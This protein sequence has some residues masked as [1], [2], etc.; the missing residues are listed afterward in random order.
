MKD[1][2]ISTQNLFNIDYSSIQTYFISLALTAIFT[3]VIIVSF[4]KILQQI[5]KRISI[6]EEKKK[7]Q[8]KVW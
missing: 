7:K 6:L 2:F 8:L 5:F 4:R 1:F 3:Y